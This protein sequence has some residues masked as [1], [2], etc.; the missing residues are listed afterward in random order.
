MT[1]SRVSSSLFAACVSLMA[2]PVY[3]GAMF[4]FPPTMD[5]FDGDEIAGKGESPNI[6][7]C[8]QAEA[9]HSFD[10]NVCVLELSEDSDGPVEASNSQ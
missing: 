2:S 8:A 5:F 9:S 7:T 6:L 10:K 3:G 1:P 4:S